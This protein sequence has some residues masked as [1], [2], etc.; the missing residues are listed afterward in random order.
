MVSQTRKKGIESPF[1]IPKARA[2]GTQGCDWHDCA[3]IGDFRSAR[4]PRN[5]ADYVWYC[6][7]HI[8]AHNKAWN[9]FEGLNDDEVEAIIKNDTV[10][11]RPTWDL[12]AKADSDKA[13][14]FA[15]GTRIRDDFGVLN[16]DVDPRATHNLPPPFP[17]DSPV[18]KAF[19]VLNLAP[20]ITID[21]LKARYKKLARL[22]HPDTNNGS[23]KSE[24]LFK[25]VGQAYQVVMKFLK[26]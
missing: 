14:A 22:H 1:H 10:W 26:D 20:P 23:K 9:Y 13:R 17:P 8:R 21:D 4:S 12:S 19:A 5:M 2:P 16:P 25:E 3:E 7:D 6:S 18:A 24:E 11:Q 15:N